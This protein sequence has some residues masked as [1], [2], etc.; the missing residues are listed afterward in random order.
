MMKRGMAIQV[1]RLFI[2]VVFHVNAKVN[3]IVMSCLSCVSWSHLQQCWRSRWMRMRMIQVDEDD[4]LYEAPPPPPPPPPDPRL[5]ITPD[6]KYHNRYWKL[7]WA[8]KLTKASI[9]FWPPEAFQINQRNYWQK[10]TGRILS[11]PGQIMRLKVHIVWW[12][13]LCWWWTTVIK[14]WRCDCNA[15]PSLF[16]IQNL[17]R[18][19]FPKGIISGQSIIDHMNWNVFVCIK[20]LCAAHWFRK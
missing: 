8:Q 9:Q 1:N 16:L 6:D 10:L 3:D 18:G 5:Q 13:K 7:D 4:P 12:P 14:V 2:S 20:N 17:I 11:W 19:S 15:T